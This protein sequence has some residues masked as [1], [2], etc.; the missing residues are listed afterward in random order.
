MAVP[1]SSRSRRGRLPGKR[2]GARPPLRGST[3][4]SLTLSPAEPRPRYCRPLLVVN[5]T[6]RRALPGGDSAGI[7]RPPI[8]GATVTSGR[9]RLSIGIATERPWL[10]QYD[11]GVPHTLD[12][13]A[14]PLQQFL[15]DT[16]ARHP[17][18]VATVF[19]A[20]VGHR[21]IEGSLTYAELDRLADRCA[22]SSRTP[23]R[24]RSSRSRVSTSSRGRRAMGR[25]SGT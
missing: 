3:T 9:L 5:A 20:V 7:R 1:P 15:T 11:P 25:R 22:G 19:G 18:A 14:I 17:R 16:A 2:A 8:A 21:L 13:P 23:G 4:A 10:K 24:R 6:A 12:Y